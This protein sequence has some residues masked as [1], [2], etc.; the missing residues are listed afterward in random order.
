MLQKLKYWFFKDEDNF[1]V[2]VQ[3]P[4]NEDAKFLLKVDN[5]SIGFLYCNNGDWFFKYTDDFKK[6]SGEYNHIIGFSNLDKTYKSDTLWPFF[7]AR[8]P[9]L[10]QPAIQEILKNEK[11]D[12]ENEAAL[13]K[14]FGEKTISNPY[15]LVV[16]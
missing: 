10:K 7:Q 1:D 4:E 15:E 6:H 3:L 16:A 14:R 12:K 9:G 5:I 11:I 2:Q 13:L 8:I